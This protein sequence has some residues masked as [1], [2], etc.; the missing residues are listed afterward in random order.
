[1]FFKYCILAFSFWTNSQT[2]INTDLCSIELLTSQLKIVTHSRS[3]LPGIHCPPRSLPKI[4]SF[5]PFWANFHRR[6]IG[7]EWC[8][9]QLQICSGVSKD[10]GANCG[11]HLDKKVQYWCSLQEEGTSSG[12]TQSP[13]THRLSS[14]LAVRARLNCTGYGVVCD[15]QPDS[16]GLLHSPSCYFLVSTKALIKHRKEDNSWRA[17]CRFYAVVPHNITYASRGSPCVPSWLVWNMKQ[18]QHHVEWTT[19]WHI[20]FKVC[21]EK[22]VWGWAQFQEKWE[23]QSLHRGRANAQGMFNSSSSEIIKTVNIDD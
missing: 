9:S 14:R 4:P 16:C 1:M 3:L 19:F 22:N 15:E 7:W 21:C 5:E 8:R 11:H 2:F 18:E 10:A 12:A 23:T 17:V 6:S 20:S 13:P